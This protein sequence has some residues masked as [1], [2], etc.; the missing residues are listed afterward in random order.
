[1]MP[2]GVWHLK[3]CPWSCDP[4]FALEQ[5][6]LFFLVLFYWYSLS[7][8]FEVNGRCS[9][10]NTFWK[11][12]IKSS[13]LLYRQQNSCSEC[14]SNFPKLVF[15]FQTT[16]NYWPGG[17]FFFLFLFSFY[18]AV[19]I[20]YP[21]SLRTYIN[22]PVP[23][24]AFVGLLWPKIARQ[25]RQCVVITGENIRRQALV[26]ALRLAT[27]AGSSHVHLPVCHLGCGD[28]F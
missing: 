6:Y 2:E 8:L 11:P 17:I 1:M 14:L 3:T 18:T 23:L 13:L 7:N 12:L 24:H 19:L 4:L 22:V 5:T 9:A 28:C 16:S 20:I 26:L 25:L 27:W 15:W 10:T 21:S